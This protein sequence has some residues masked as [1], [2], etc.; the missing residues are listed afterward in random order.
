MP[1]GFD[2]IVI[3]VHDLE[4][5]IAD[6]AAAGFT[7]TPGGEH[8][9]GISHNALV[10]FQDGAYFELI[11]FHDGGEGH[12][13]HWPLT[14]R[15]GEDMVDYA[16]RTNDLEQELRELRANGLAY[17][18]PKDG[19]RYRPDGQR[20]DWQTIRYGGGMAP[21]RL[22]FY[23]NDLT[24]R[25]LRVP[26]GAQAVHANE[27]TGIAGVSVV[28][29][30]LAAASKDFAALTGDTGVEVQSALPDVAGA[31]RFPIGAA[32]IEAVQPAEHPSDLRTYL[33]NRGELP[34]QV[35]L[36]S[37]SEGEARLPEPLTHGARLLVTSGSGVTA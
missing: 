14:L 34:Y 17:S 29:S 13:T 35:T 11:A 6:Y 2:H 23:C 4:Q 27:V 8:K 33:E 3:A 30:D 18:D 12:A 1:I 37:S 24:E 21:S 5:T 15:Q 9:H 22:P 25:S 28:V 26:G 16:L 10:T 36:V 19:G 32:W 7:I 31:R 20:V